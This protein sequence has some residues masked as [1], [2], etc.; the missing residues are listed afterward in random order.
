MKHTTW[1]KC[2]RDKLFLDTGPDEA[3][4]CFAVYHGHILLG[5]V[6][7]TVSEVVL[8]QCEQD[9]LSSQAQF[10]IDCRSFVYTEVKQ[11]CN[12]HEVTK[13][14]HPSLFEA[15]PDYDYYEKLAT[16][17]DNR[18]AFAVVSLGSSVMLRAT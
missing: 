6:Q 12:L 15:D 11:R 5:H 16:C 2:S 8:D 10:N 1:D 4:G 17:P 3:I 9:C 18:C 7:K 13:D 14:M